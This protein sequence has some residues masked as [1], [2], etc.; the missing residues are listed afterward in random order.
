MLTSVVTW[1][2]FKWTDEETSTLV[3]KKKTMKGEGQWFPTFLYQELQESRA[4]Y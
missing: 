2:T 4:C 1:N 3:L